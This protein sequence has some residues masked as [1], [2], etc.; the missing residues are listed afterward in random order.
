MVVLVAYPPVV[1]RVRLQ[2][3]RRHAPTSRGG[4]FAAF[5]NLDRTGCVVDHPP[6]RRKGIPSIRITERPSLQRRRQRYTGRTL[7]RRNNTRRI[8]RVVRCWRCI[9][10]IQLWRETTGRILPCVKPIDSIIINNVRKKET[11]IGLCSI[12]PS[13]YQ[14]RKLAETTIRRCIPRLVSRDSG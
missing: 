2:H 4:H 12:D 10:D 9:I 3:T 5:V 8:R 1:H 11:I 6:T 13:L 7:R 14:N